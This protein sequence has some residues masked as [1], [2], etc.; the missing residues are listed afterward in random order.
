MLTRLKARAGE[1]RERARAEEERERARVQE[2]RERERSM[3]EVFGQPELLRK[4]VEYPSAGPMRLVCKDLR[5]A[6]D[7]TVTKLT[8]RVVSSCS[9]SV[10]LNRR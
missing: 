4:I 7:S 2:E 6:F 10:K 9:T 5:N 8:R 1:E 3:W